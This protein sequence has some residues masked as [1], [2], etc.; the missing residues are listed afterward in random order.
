MPKW[1]R[2]RDKKV[3]LVIVELRGK[4][5]RITMPMLRFREKKGTIAGE[6]REG[7]DV[8]RDGLQGQCGI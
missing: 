5:T 8:I 7:S 3:N 4:N 1:E 2:I 6:D